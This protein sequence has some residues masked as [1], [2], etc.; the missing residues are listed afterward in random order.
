MRDSPE[1]AV[2]LN[3]IAANIESSDLSG[4]IIQVEEEARRLAATY[5]EAGLSEQDIAAE[6]LRRALRRRAAVIMTL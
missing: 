3:S 1:R 5:P 6:F 2:V 4:R